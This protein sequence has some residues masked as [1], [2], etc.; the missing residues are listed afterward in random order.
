MVV[1]YKH[2]TWSFLF[3]LF[4][5]RF[6]WEGSPKIDKQ[7][8]MVPTYSSLS[9]GGPRIGDL[10]LGFNLLFLWKWETPSHQTDSLRLRS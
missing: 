10:D 6:G 2:I 4:S 5:F 3:L 7:E 1:V 9:T 8:N